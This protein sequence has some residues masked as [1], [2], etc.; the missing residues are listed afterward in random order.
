MVLAD[1]EA[2]KRGI[3]Q[4]QAR[5]DDGYRYRREIVVIRGIERAKGRWCKVED[6]Q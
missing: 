6:T 4:E 3:A 1:A 5:Y 2:W